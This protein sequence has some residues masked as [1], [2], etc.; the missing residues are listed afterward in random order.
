MKKNI[1]SLSFI[2]CINILNSIVYSQILHNESF[3]ATTFLPTGWVAVGTATDWSR[4]TTFSNPLVGVPHT[5]AGMARM[6]YP[7]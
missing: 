2:L 5:G 6:R 3:D 7:N 4:S 1:L